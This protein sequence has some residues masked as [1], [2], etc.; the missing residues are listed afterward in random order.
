MPIDPERLLNW[1]FEDLEHTY[2][3]RDTIL[4]ALGLG[5]GADPLDEAQLRFVYEENLAALPTMAVVLGYPGFWVKDPATGV[6]WKKVLHGEQG[7]E[8]F[9]PLPAEGTVI[10]RTR[11]TG[12]IDKGA[13]KGALLLSDRDVIDKKSGDLLCRVSGTSFL[14]GDG[15]FG[16]SSGPAPAPHAMPERAP[17]LSVSI[18]TLPQA[19]LIYRL[20]GDYNPLHADPKVAAAG[21]FKA[22]ILHGLCTYGVAGRALLQAVGGSKPESLRRMDVRFTSPV[23]P[24]ETIVTEIWKGEGGAVSFRAKVAERDVVVLNNGRAEFG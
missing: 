17:D 9:K 14:R 10:G 1:P 15:G 7:L 21:G 5:L 2:T 4:Y 13:G 16:G 22:P 24:G 8:V 3:A 11:V 23:Y 12:I 6:D 18:P 20:S 19:A